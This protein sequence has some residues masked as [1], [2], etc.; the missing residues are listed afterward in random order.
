M[1]YDLEDAIK[2]IVRNVMSSEPYNLPMIG[3]LEMK[4]KELEEKLAK[5][6]KG[7]ICMKMCAPADP[8]KEFTG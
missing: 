6:E 5:F 7:C 4:V 1:S 2:R 8:T 3:I